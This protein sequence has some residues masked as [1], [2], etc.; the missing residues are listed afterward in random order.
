MKRE[1]PKALLVIAEPRPGNAKARRSDMEF[2]PI[3][4]KST[5]RDAR[6][7]Q[8]EDDRNDRKLAKRNKVK[9]TG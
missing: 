1:R 8:R 6:R 5:E 3:R 4:G 7:T 2:E 9:F